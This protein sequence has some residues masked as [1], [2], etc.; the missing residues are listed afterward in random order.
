MRRLYLGTMLVS[1]KVKYDQ[2]KEAVA[3][4]KVEDAHAAGTLQ[5]VAAEVAAREIARVRV[6]ERRARVMLAYDAME[7]S[8]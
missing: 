2:V 4:A 5:Q 7:K 8:R 6:P 1:H 3:F